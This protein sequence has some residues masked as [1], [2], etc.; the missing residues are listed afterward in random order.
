MEKEQQKYKYHVGSLKKKYGP[1]APCFGEV[2]IYVLPSTGGVAKRFWESLPRIEFSTFVS[3]LRNQKT[4]K[5]NFFRMYTLE[6]FYYGDVP[7][8]FKTGYPIYPNSTSMKKERE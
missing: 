4:M 1:Q 6:Y 7:D 3:V 2:A 8:L 5:N